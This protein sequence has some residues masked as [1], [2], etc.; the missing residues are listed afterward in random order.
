MSSCPLRGFVMHTELVV[1]FNCD[2]YKLW[3]SSI[4]ATFLLCQSYPEEFIFFLSFF[5]ES[6]SSINCWHNWWIDLSGSIFP[7]C[8]LVSPAAVTLSIR[9]LKS[10]SAQYKVIPH[11]VA[12]AS[13]DAYKVQINT[14]QLPSIPQWMSACSG[15][16]HQE[17]QD[18]LHCFIPLYVILD[19]K[20][21]LNWFC[22]TICCQLKVDG[23]ASEKKV[24][25]EYA[26]KHLLTQTTEVCADADARAQPDTRTQINETNSKASSK[27]HTRNEK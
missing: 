10:V 11:C 4:Y 20:T 3:E 15:C 24:F 19:W 17:S 12:I 22:S 14:L 26:T 2:I 21:R 5:H 16:L 6:E 1:C 25:W 23:S 13:H 8:K 27:M 18:K 7:S 9:G